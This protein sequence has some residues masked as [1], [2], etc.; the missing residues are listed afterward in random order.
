MMA[1]GFGFNNSALAPDF[2][3]AWQAALEAS[4]TNADEIE[5][6]ATLAGKADS[7]AFRQF[8]ASRGLHVLALE[9]SVAAVFAEQAMTRSELSLQRSGLPSV[10]E[11]CALAAAASLSLR[12]SATLL[13]RRIVRGNVTCAVARTLNKEARA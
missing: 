10:A 6:V 2:E 13:L 9:H 8:A 7:P 1:A 4:G 11:C 5:T 12:Q 3:S